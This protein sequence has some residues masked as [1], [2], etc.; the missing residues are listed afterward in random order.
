MP[1]LNI[2]SKFARLIVYSYLDSVQLLKDIATLSKTEHQL[3]LGQKAALLGKNRR[4]TI[5][6]PNNKPLISLPALQEKRM[7]YDK[8]LYLA[9]QIDI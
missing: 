3:I 4:L 2:D 8:A 5:K 1:K 7:S 6:I 9:N